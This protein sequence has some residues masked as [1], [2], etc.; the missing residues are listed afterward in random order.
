MKIKNY[1]NLN[2]NGIINNNINNNI[3]GDYIKINFDLEYSEKNKKLESEIINYNIHSFYYDKN[4]CRV[5]DWVNPTIS[6]KNFKTKL[7]LSINNIK[8]NTEKNIYEMHFIDRA[9]KKEMAGEIPFMI[10]KS[11][12]NNVSEFIKKIAYEDL[13]C[14]QIADYFNILI[15]PHSKQFIKFQKHILYEIDSNNSNIL[16]VINLNVKYIISEHSLSIQ[17]NNS[18]IPTQRI[19]QNFSHFSY[20]ISGGQ[21]FISDIIYDKELKKVTKYKL[22]N[23]KG[24]GYKKI[25][26]FFSS[27][28]CDNTCKALNLAHPRKKLNP[29]IVNENFFRGRYLLDINL[30]ECCS[31]PI[32]PKEESQESKNCGFCSWKIAQSKVTAVC[33]QC[34][35]PFLY[36]SYANNSQFINYPDK[37]DKCSTN[38]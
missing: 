17:L 8:K 5:I 29:V 28:I 30:C 14:E 31:C 36:S 6:E 12:Y 4:S 24:E 20:Q 9:L 26:E 22:Y 18:V 23:L 13:I 2:Q 15:L 32:E 27:H 38:F 37:C 7:Q 11:E 3:D 34:K 25:L 10:K 35:F 33:S 16:N 21:F 1:S 19:F